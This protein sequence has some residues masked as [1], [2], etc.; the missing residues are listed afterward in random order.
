MLPVSNTPERRQ[1]EQLNGPPAAPLTTRSGDCGQAE[2]IT[3]RA[4]PA[5]G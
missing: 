3:F 4:P 2:D 1:A 5:K